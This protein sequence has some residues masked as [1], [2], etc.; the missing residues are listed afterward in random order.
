MMKEDA[1][2]T[3][4]SR[5]KGVTKPLSGQ[6]KQDRQRSVRLGM[7]SF[8]G[9]EEITRLKSFLCR[10][11]TAVEEEGR[12]SVILYWSNQRQILEISGANPEIRGVQ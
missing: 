8:S 4:A 9:C 10:H 11:H 12:K 3:S 1:A 6:R 2:E 5:E 7:S